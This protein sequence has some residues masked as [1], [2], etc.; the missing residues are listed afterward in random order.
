MET[1]SRTAGSPK[2]IGTMCSGGSVILATGV[3]LLAALPSRAQSPTDRSEPDS[4]VSTLALR[5]MRSGAM[6]GGILGAVTIG[7]LSQ[8]LCEASTCS[9]SLFEGVIMGLFGGGAFG[10]GV[11]LVLGSAFRAGTL[12]EGHGLPSPALVLIGGGRWAG[13]SEVRGFG[14]FLGVRGLRSTTSRV[15]FGIEVGYLGGSTESNTFTTS[16]RDGVPIRFDEHADRA[17]W[18]AGFVAVRRLGDPPV[19]G[20][21]LLA[22]TGAYAM[23]E[24]ITFRRSGGVEPGTPTE[25]R[26]HSWQP[27]PGVAVGAGTSRPTIGRIRIGG[28]A[29]VHMLVGAGDGGVLPLLSLAFQA[30]VGG[31]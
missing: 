15:R 25:G 21:Y 24:A 12:P 10:G 27:V 19:A 11:G 29:R 14:P 1:T 31:A 6:A 9:P 2:G 28:E 16:S 18:T 3:L 30:R 22:S 7:F 23:E 4:A 8:A 26:S 17:I 20:P 5:G 13:A